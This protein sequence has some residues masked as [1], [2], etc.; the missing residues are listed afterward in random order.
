MI[1]AVHSAFHTA[2]KRSVRFTSLRYT[3][4]LGMTL[5]CA[6]LVPANVNAG[7]KDFAFEKGVLA[8]CMPAVMTGSSFLT[9]GLTELTDDEKRRYIGVSSAPSYFLGQPD[10]GA[11]LTVVANKGCRVSVLGADQAQLAT[12]PDK[13]LTCDGCPFEELANPPENTRVFAG[14]GGVTVKFTQ[15]SQLTVFSAVRPN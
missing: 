3:A 15:Q 12:F 7:P 11:I 6:T 10:S 2:V 14:P 4:V 13:W 9:Q 8:I 5:F 1:N